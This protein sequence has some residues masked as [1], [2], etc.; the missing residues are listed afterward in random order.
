MLSKH[1]GAQ[2][3]RTQGDPPVDIRFGTDQYVQCT[4]VVPEP[5]RSQPIFSNLDAPLPVRTYYEHRSVRLFPAG[6]LLCIDDTLSNSAINLFSSSRPITKG[7]D[8]SEESWIEKTYFTTEEA[9]PTVLRR[10]EIIAVEVV[11]VSPIE[12][13]LSDL[14]QRTKELM[15][16]YARYSAAVKT[17]QLLSTNPLT[18]ALN[19]AVDAPEENEVPSF[20]H[21]LTNEYMMKNPDK[22]QTI[23]RLR[24]AVD[25]H[26]RVNVDFDHRLQ[27]EDLLAPL[28]F[29]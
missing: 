23:E 7:R 14:E 5:D 18:M 27:T 8:G 20:R 2:L 6:P 28:R 13:V 22:I 9:F 17:G 21:F 12:R 4:S 16:F 15:G 11:E 19:T 10:S 25:Q 1:P 26:V 24:I 29:G 3:L